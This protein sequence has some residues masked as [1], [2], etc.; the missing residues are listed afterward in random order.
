MSIV[1]KSLSMGRLLFEHNND[2][3][4]NQKLVSLNALHGLH[5]RDTVIIIKKELVQVYLLHIPAKNCD[6]NRT[7]S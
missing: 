6:Q 1:W 4:K 5:L 3:R 7:N 2:T